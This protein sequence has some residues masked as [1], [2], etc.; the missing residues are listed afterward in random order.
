MP[1]KICSNRVQSELSRNLSLIGLIETRECD[2]KYI[3]ESMR[4]NIL[5]KFHGYYRMPCRAPTCLVYLL[6]IITMIS[7]NMVQMCVDVNMHK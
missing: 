4:V 3:K 6:Y 2:S 1:R 5:N 7:M